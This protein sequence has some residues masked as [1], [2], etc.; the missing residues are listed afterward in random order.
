VSIPSEHRPLSAYTAALEQAGLLIECIREPVPD[1]AVVIGR[2][3][4]ARWLRIP[5]FLYVRARKLKIA[6]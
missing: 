1:A 4:L 5:C 6:T 3:S 2:P